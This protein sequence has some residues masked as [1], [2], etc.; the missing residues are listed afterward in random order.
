MGAVADPSPDQTPVQEGTV[1]L[2]VPPPDED[3]GVQR[4]EAALPGVAARR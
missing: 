4:A 2:V 3:P 1:G